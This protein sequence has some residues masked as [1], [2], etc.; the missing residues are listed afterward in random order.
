VPFVSDDPLDCARHAYPPP[1]LFYPLS[2]GP[3]EITPNFENKRKTN[4]TRHR[5]GRW[6]LRRSECKAEESQEEAEGNRY[7]VKQENV[8]TFLTKR[9]S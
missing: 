9:L 2:D 1:I 4:I 5:N 6:D 8:E 3:P 7:D